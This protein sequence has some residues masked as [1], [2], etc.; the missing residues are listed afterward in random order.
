MTGLEHKPATEQVGSPRPKVL[1][2]AEAVRVCEYDLTLEERML[3]KSAI[4]TVRFSK[5]L[6]R[7]A[8]QYRFMEKLK[9][10]CAKHNKV[11][12]PCPNSYLSL[13][14]SKDKPSSV[15][16]TSM[17]ACGRRSSMLPTGWG[18]KYRRRPQL[19][20]GLY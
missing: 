7:A 20:S 5:E 9:R 12:K 14:P 10:K 16:K 17:G 3:K 1:R 4:K 18:S 8:V 2:F 11:V 19:T 6:R 13:V 15:S